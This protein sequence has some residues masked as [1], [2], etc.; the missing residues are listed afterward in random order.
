MNI[1]GKRVRKIIT[2][3]NVQSDMKKPSFKIF[4]SR[5][6]QLPDLFGSFDLKNV[7]ETSSLGSITKL[8]L[9]YSLAKKIGPGI[10]KIEMLDE[11]KHVGNLMVSFR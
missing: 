8:E 9:T 1:R 3:L 11:N 5:G 7:K 2:S 6:I 10:Y 4:D